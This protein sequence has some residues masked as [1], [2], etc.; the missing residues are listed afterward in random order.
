MTYQVLLSPEAELDLEDA[1]NWCQEPQPKGV[2]LE[3]EI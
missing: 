1:Y 2:R 3:R